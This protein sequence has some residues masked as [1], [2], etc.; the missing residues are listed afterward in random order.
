[1]KSLRELIAKQL[2]DFDDSQSG[3]DQDAYFRWKEHHINDALL[4][5]ASYLFSLFVDEFGRP[6]TFKADCTS[7]VITI[8]MKCAKPL[9]VISVGDNRCDNVVENDTNSRNLLGLLGTECI[10]D[11]KNNY[12]FKFISSHTIQFTQ[13]IEKGEKIHLVCA[14]PPKDISEVPQSILDEHRIFIVNLA[15]WFLYLSDSES[16]SNLERAQIH[17]AFIKD[18][19][20]NVLLQE[21]SLREDDYIKGRRK[22]DDR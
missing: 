5:S 21:F 9:N 20:Q 14:R 17:Y 7:C 19:V 6:F 8:P 3:V 16:I 22:V 4:L 18:Y 1:M 2:N 15:L 10:S 11:S 12:T 13:E